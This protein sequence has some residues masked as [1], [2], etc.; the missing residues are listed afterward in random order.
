MNR[1]RYTGFYGYKNT[2]AIKAFAAEKGKVLQTDFPATYYTTVAYEDSYASPINSS[3]WFLPS[4]G[5]C[6]YWFNNEGVL[7][8]S[9]KKSSGNENY[10]WKSSYWSS[11]E[12]GGNPAGNAWYLN[13]GYSDVSYFNKLDSYFCVRACLAF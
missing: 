11:S 7:L 3:G 2:N 12:D 10:R 13:F 1:D 5:Q 8:S 6:W 9:M 4:A